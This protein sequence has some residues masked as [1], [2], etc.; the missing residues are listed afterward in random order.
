MTQNIHI[1]TADDLNQ[2]KVL[3][4]EYA[5]SLGFDLCFQDFEEE[6]RS[7]PGK[8]SPPDGTLLVAKQEDGEITGC[9]ALRPLNPEVCE[10]KRL[11]VRPK[12]RGRSIGRALAHAI[13]VEAAKSGYKAMRLDT[14]SS[15][16]QAIGLYK[17]LGFLPTQPYRHNP[18]PG[19]MYLELKLKE[20][21]GRAV[22]PETT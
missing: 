17:S 10:M 3:F 6:L 11:Y 14:V 22:G 13:I 1:Q 7:L 16:K 5:E 4:R 15:M 2:V 19:T 8:Y 18:I 9:V 20:D 21:V 12:R